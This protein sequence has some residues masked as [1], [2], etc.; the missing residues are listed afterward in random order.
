LA[1]GRAEDAHHRGQVNA[2]KIVVAALCIIRRHGLEGLN[3]R[4]LGEELGSSV[5]A[6]YYHVSSKRALVELV[7][8]RTLGQLPTPGPQAGDWASR[9]ETMLVASWEMSRRYPGIEQLLLA[10]V[11][12]PH[13]DRLSTYLREVLA[14]SGIVEAERRSIEVVLSYFAAGVTSGISAN[15]RSS[16]QLITTASGALQFYLDG[17]RSR[18]TTR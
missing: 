2:E 12:R 14:E 18:R 7:A 4:R 16:K 11:G 13:L 5:G 10:P 1:A 3:M 8:D 9:L 17:L 6:A 15:P